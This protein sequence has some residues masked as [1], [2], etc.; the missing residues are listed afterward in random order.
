M[1][2]TD[3]STAVDDQPVASEALEQA[4]ALPDTL[5]SAAASNTPDV[6]REPGLILTRSQLVNL[7]RYEVR[8][9]SLPV[10]LK[11]VIGYLGYESGAGANL[12]AKDFQ[13]SFTIIRNHALQWAPIRADM[14]N[15]GSEL[16]VFADQIK[17]YQHSIQE[18]YQD[19]RTQ[20]TDNINPADRAD[21]V[22]YI[23]EVGNLVRE[24]QTATNVLNARLNDFAEELSTKVMPTVQIKLRSIDNRKQPLEISRLN[25]EIE[26]RARRI[27][28]KQQE[29]KK[30]VGIA[31]GTGVVVLAAGIYFSVQ[32]EKIRKDLNALRAA[33]NRSIIE[34]ER[35]N[36]INGALQ[37]V[38][39][40]ISDLQELVFD[41]DI[42]TKNLTVVWTAL[43]T[44]MTESVNQ[45][46]KVTNALSLR[47]LMNAF[48]LVAVPW[49]NIK[50]DADKLLTV[51]S[52]ADDAFRKEY[53]HL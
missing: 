22:N 14:M 41:A 13:E 49:A 30:A 4:Q 42:A 38:R 11:D 21:F 7:K 18:I 50:R 32:A 25:A 19:L 3:N 40:D 15:I 2:I 51:F 34:L 6:F 45:A 35:Q 43:D 44:Y 37:R 23:Q 33:Q 39:F 29:Y 17:T 16:S 27:D 36:K 20:V 8:G 53:G 48:E 9:L 28:E 52:E 47:R 24:R 46:N 31:V 26:E 1:M 5:V 12:E 10:I